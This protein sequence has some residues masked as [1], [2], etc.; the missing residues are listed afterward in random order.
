MKKGYVEY[1]GSLIEDLENRN[2]RRKLKVV[3]GPS[4]VEVLVDGVRFLAFCSND[5]LGLANHPDIKSS[6]SEG[7]K[8]FGGGS[9]ASHLISG[10]NIAHKQLEAMLERTQ[11]PFVG[12]SRALYFSTG[13][14]ANLATICSLTNVGS[15]NFS[16][17]IFSE[18]LNHASLID[19]IRLAQ[20]QNKVNVHIYRH[21]DL[22]HLEQLLSLDSSDLRL[23]VTDGVFSMDG[24]ICDVPRL[25]DFSEKYDAMLLVDD[26]DGFGVIGERGLGVLDYYKINPLDRGG[27]RMIYVGTLGKAAGISGA[28]VVASKNIIEWIIQKGRSYIYTTASPPFI[29]YALMKS[30]EIIIE[31]KLQKILKDNIFYFKK[32]MK[33][34]KWT[35]LPSDSAIQPL[36]IGANKDALRIDRELQERRLWIPAIRPP[37]VPEGTARLR[38]TLSAAHTKE[39]IDLLSRALY[40]LE[41]K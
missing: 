3:E 22:E 10:H 27:G 2:L 13:Y 11:A 39:Q 28:F 15:N 18:E 38:I 7:I 20:Q 29:S 1:F 24:D 6:L 4:D 5:Y 17:S 30:V 8:K 26:A 9:G 36:M 37:T 32:I 16:V 12:D 34:E 40:E 19:G 33:F 23:I 31:N 21:N 35:L 14:M 41:R 25:L